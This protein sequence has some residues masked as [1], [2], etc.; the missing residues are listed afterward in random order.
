MNCNRSVI[1]LFLI[2]VCISSVAFAGYIREVICSDVDCD[3]KSNVSFFGG[4]GY[5]KITGYCVACGKF[6]YLTWRR[7]ENPPLPSAKIWNP[8]TGEIELLYPC[9]DCKNSFLPINNIN[10]LKYCPKC[11]KKTI[12]STQ[13]ITHYD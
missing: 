4:K 11:K 3:F 9:P 7:R 5:D 10:Q 1:L 13:G 2:F 6:V 8:L 12:T